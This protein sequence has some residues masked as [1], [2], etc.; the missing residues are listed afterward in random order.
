M[1]YEVVLAWSLMRAVL[2]SLLA[3]SVAMG[4]RR[5][6]HGCTSGSA[7]TVW[8]AVAVAPLFMPDLLVGFTYRLTSAQLVH[9]DVATELLYGGLLTVRVTALQLVVLLLLPV[10][11]VSNSAVHLWHLVP[12][13]TGHWWVTAV[14]LRLLGPWRSAVVAFLAGAVWCFQEFE[15]AAL[16]QVDQHPISLPVWLFDAHAGGESLQVSLRYTANTLAVELLL[17][18]PFLMLLPG[19]EIAAAPQSG[20]VCRPVPPAIAAMLRL[21]V[22]AGVG[23]VCAWPILANAAGIVGGFAVLAQQQALPD[24]ISQVTLSIVPPLLASVLALLAASVLATGSRWVLVLSVVPGLCGSLMISLVLLGLFQL[25]LLNVLYDTSLP[26]IAG[27][28]LFALPRAVTLMYVLRVLLPATSRHSLLL[29]RRSDSGSVRRNTSRLWWRFSEQRWL[30]AAAV[31]T[32]WCYWDVSIVSNLRPVHFEPAVV[33]LYGEM[34][35]GRS[36]SL[37][38]T[39]LLAAVLPLLLFVVVAAI[40]RCVKPERGVTGV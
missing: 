32:H 7:R 29:L 40:Y 30:L 15:T 13:R 10:S 31:L 25:P 28:F 37:V 18:L 34:H 26:M 21:A 33:R 12:R 6:I 3:L 19:R 36:E 20:P 2:V 14:R 5:L 39:S 38:A 24:R 11:A 22:L 17:L 23:C 35:W 27:L 1:T 9:S 4:L 8:V 16:V